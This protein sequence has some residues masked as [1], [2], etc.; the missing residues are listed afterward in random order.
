M[1]T[2][3]DKTPK[4]SPIPVSPLLARYTLNYVFQ[5]WGEKWR[6]LEDSHSKNGLG[7]NVPTFK[8]NPPCEAKNL[9]FSNPSGVWV[10]IV[11]HDW[12]PP[13]PDWRAPRVTSHFWDNEG[14]SLMDGFGQCTART[15]HW[16]QSKRKSVI[17]PT[18]T[19]GRESQP[20]SSPERHML[21]V[22]CTLEMQ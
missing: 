3:G 6:H 9:L 4:L 20:E 1:K 12:A 5:N 8:A 14:K 21:V 22:S 2:G 7:A 11:L 10:Y 19:L 18:G 13:G 16:T 15:V 17:F